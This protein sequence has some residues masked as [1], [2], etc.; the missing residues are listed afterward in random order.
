MVAV[1]Y[2]FCGDYSYF[3][4]AQLG[5]VL[6]HAVKSYSFKLWIALFK[7]LISVILSLWTPN[8][9]THM[10][11]LDIP[12]PDLA[13]FYCYINLHSGKAFH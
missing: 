9:N 6:G 3:K 2:T 7:S 13:P 12:I 11:F 5:H 1:T 10:C 8:H 4:A